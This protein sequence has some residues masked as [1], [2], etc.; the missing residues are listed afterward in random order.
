MM[1][2]A[3]LYKQPDLEEKIL[4]PTINE[5]QIFT[6]PTVQ[7]RLQSGELDA[8]SAYKI[9]PGPF[10]LPYIKLPNEINL[11]GENVHAEH[12]DVG[13]SVGGKTYNPEPLIYYAAV[14]KDAPNFAAAMASTMSRAADRVPQQAGPAF[15]RGPA[16]GPG[17]A[18][19]R[20]LALLGMG[21]SP[22]FS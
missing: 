2:A 4:G 10:H 13:L 7:A 21:R 1:L 15:A 8:A 3:K 22:A 12:P 17:Q 18:F 16:F 9:Q 6:E 11:S 14:L 20:G 19:G 5:K